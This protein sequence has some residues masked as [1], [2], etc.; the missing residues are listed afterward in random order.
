MSKGFEITDDTTISEIY[1]AVQ[2]GI[3]T[4]DEVA[5]ACTRI[6]AHAMLDR[7][8]LLR[9][10]PS[11]RGAEPFADYVIPNRKM[12][13]VTPEGWSM[14]KN[15]WE[16]IRDHFH[17]G[18]EYI[19]DLETS[20]DPEPR[21]RELDH[22]LAGALWNVVDTSVEGFRALPGRIWLPYYD[23]GHYIDGR[24]IKATNIIAT[25]SLYSDD[26]FKRFG[27]FR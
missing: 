15:W 10:P 24:Q 25:W 9:P 2:A 26:A 6:G 17:F 1:K 5:R 11:G 19:T 22:D 27:R 12:R 4:A 18:M 23:G 8:S 20:T 3:T 21:N 7:G 14:W 16:P 13:K